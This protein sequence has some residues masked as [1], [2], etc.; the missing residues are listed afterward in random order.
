[1]SLAPREKIIATTCALLE[2]QGYHA[3]GLNQIVKES[4]AAKGS[5]YHYFPSGKE[6]IASEAIRSVSLLTA[7]RVRRHLADVSGAA[8]AVETFVLEIA[9]LVE[10]SDFQAGGPLTTVALET[11]TTS[12]RLNLACREAYSR[13]Q[14]VFEE[15]LAGKGFSA[16]LSASLAVM[17]V[18]AV[19][20]G[21]IL[22]RTAH[23]GDPLRIVAAHLAGLIRSYSPSSTGV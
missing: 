5:L 16:P 19:E 17:I 22:S 20:G 7:G 9:R 4:G 15:K 1:M 21:I 8:E 10:E 2:S 6:E 11:A 12:P 3:T 18:A 14:A 13:L 23:S